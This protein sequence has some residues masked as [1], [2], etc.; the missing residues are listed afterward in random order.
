MTDYIETTNTPIHPSEILKDILE[1]REISQKNLA[2]RLGISAKH[3]NELLKGQVSFTPAMALKLE[4]VLDTPAQTWLKL[5]SNYDIIKSRLEM[6][7]QLNKQF[8]AEKDRLTDFKY[9]YANLQNWGF[10]SKTTV[11]KNRYMNILE[12]FATPSLQLLTNNYHLAKFRQGTAEADVYS[13]AAWMRVGERQFEANRP[14]KEFNAQDFKK[15]LETIRQ[16]TTQPI[17]QASRTLVDICAKA[18]VTVVFTPYFSKTHINGSTKWIAPSRPLIQLSERNKKSDTLWFTFFHEAG[19]ILLHSKKQNYIS[20]DSVAESDHFEEEKAADLFARNTLI[21][22]VDY[23]K[24]IQAG[25][26]DHQSILSFSRQQKI[27]PDIVAGRL[28]YEK[29][30]EWSY[31]DVF[32]KRIK[33]EKV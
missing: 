26:F 15:S 27:G 8:I 18:G 6:S 20:W 4:F 31:A 30:I 14:E 17:N 3:M 32:A 2:D 10:V 24:F 13:I 28:A 12:F 5:Q 25:K 29:H 1:D 11:R 7:D 22:S 21:P 23:I 9:C 19:H 33:L 16:L